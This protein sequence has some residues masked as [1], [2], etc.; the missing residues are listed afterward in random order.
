MAKYT[1]FGGNGFI[2]SHIV[3]KLEDA[4]YD[5][6]VPARDD[7]SIYTQDLGVV[8]YCAGN[9]DCA[10][11]PFN[12]VEANITLFAKLVEK[13]NFQ[14][15]IYVSSTRVYM[16]GPG[17]SENDDLIICNDD[18][19][20]LFNITKL[21]A[22][23]LCIRSGRNVLIVRPSNVY[24]L[25]LNSALFLPSII[26]HAIN[27]GEV[28]MFVKPAYTKDY[29]SVN[30]VADSCIY[31]SEADTEKGHIYNIAA[32]YNTNA[33]SIADVLEKHT[34]C[35]INWHEVNFPRESFP[36][37]DISAIKTIYKD[38]N[39]RNVLKDLEFMIDNFKNELGKVE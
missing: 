7:D 11:T 18:N 22:E 5:A 17:S 27:N 8:I 9:G 13:A 38:Y 14:K 6:W 36:V 3:K 26:R 39:P 28:N 1:V 12:V 4:G 20:R 31:L 37:T 21:A 33:Q 32:G 16:N 19:R 30:D 15:L 35:K 25:A 10:N 29:V 2:G 24:G 34:Q 23:E